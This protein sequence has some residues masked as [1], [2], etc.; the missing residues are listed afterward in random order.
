MSVQIYTPGFKPLPWI[1]ERG[2]VPRQYRHLWA[3][4]KVLHPL[5]GNHSPRDIVGQNHGTLGGGTDDPTWISSNVGRALHFDATGDYYTVADNPDLTLPDDDWTIAWYMRVANN[6]GP[7]F[8]YWHSWGAFHATPSINCFIYEDSVST[9]PPEYNGGLKAAIDD[10]SG[11][12]VQSPLSSP[13][14][15]SADW[16]LVVLRRK[17]SGTTSVRW[18]AD[19]IDVNTGHADEG[20]IAAINRADA[21]YLGMRSD[22]SGTRRLLGDI[23][24]WGK[25]DRA[26]NVGEMQSLRA[27]PFGLIRPA[28][29]RVSI[30]VTAPPA[31]LSIPIAMYHR[32][33]AEIS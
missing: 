7:S 3:E 16:V 17:G 4:L 30:G 23:A 22:D 29:R 26:L 11:T 33:M 18:F 28:W 24:W 20:D 14:F 12:V 2:R 10:S 9:T 15:P 25:W 27:D 21:L 8:Q 1:V 13:L 31:G 19:A 5:W 32:K 6:A